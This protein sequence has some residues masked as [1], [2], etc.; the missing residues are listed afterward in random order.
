VV[1]SIIALFQVLCGGCLDYEHTIV[2]GDSF[3]TS[4][5]S[6]AH[7]SIV[8]PIDNLCAPCYTAANR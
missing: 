8:E 5:N 1:V 3:S 2:E 4:A 7:P 6:C